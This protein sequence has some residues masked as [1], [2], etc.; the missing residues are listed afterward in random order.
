MGS[1]EERDGVM[2]KLINM[3]F[4]NIALT[5]MPSIQIT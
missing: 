3:L 2:D 1:P 4:N 5:L